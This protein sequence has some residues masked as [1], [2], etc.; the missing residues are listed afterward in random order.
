M[1]T[2][3]R[4]LRHLGFKISGHIKEF[5]NPHNGVKNR[6]MSVNNYEFFG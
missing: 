3:T 6:K 2:L 1:S 4:K 5:V